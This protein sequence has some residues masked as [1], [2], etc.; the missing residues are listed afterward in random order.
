MM[1]GFEL[2]VLL[3]SLFGVG[4]SFLGWRLR[5][6][7]EPPRTIPAHARQEY[8]TI[9]LIFD[10]DLDLEDLDV[11]AWEDE[12]QMPDPWGGGQ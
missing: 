11:P 12:E 10:R 7:G 8:R 4:L 9:R 6:A 2:L 3:G 5:S 1:T